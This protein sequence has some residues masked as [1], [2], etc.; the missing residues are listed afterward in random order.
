[1]ENYLPEPVLST[2]FDVTTDKTSLKNGKTKMDV[3][4]YF[5][6]TV[7]EFKESYNPGLNLSEMIEFIIN[8]I[9]AWNR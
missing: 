1:M 4:T 2:F 9:S 7:S 6:N 5:E 8:H 3:A